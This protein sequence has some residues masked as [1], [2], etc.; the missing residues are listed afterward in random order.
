MLKE[1]KTK[2]ME[3]MIMKLEKMGTPKEQC[4]IFESWK[5]TDSR[6]KCRNPECDNLFSP[7]KH[8]WNKKYCSEKCA[9][10]VQHYRQKRRRIMYRRQRLPDNDLRFVLNDIEECLECGSKNIIYDYIKREIV[11]SQC[12]LVIED[13]II[14]KTTQSKRTLHTTY[15]DDIENE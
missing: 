6:R 14:E 12:G 4:Q 7:S 13:L 5:V 2:F 15:S 9:L 10:K 1:N 8:A 11:C 3:K